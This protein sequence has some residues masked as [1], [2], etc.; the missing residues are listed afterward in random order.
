[1]PFSPRLAGQ[2]AIKPFFALQYLSF[3]F[4]GMDLDL[5][6]LDVETKMIV[7]THVLVRDPDQRK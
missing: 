5:L 3:F 7:N 4:F 2:H 6:V 1:M